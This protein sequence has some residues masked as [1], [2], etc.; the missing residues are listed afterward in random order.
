MGYSSGPS[1]PE[2]N[3]PISTSKAGCT[4]HPADPIKT[5]VDGG[6][7]HEIFLVG[8]LVEPTHLEKYA[9]VKLGDVL[10]SPIFFGEKNK[11]VKPTPRFCL[12]GEISFC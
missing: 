12:L 5:G 3:E 6:T 9:N 11:Y 2:R 7:K 8:G 10:P 1:L 4:R